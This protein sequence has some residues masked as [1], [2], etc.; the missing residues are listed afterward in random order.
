[1]SGII[2]SE[3]SKSGII[4]RTDG[5]LVGISWFNGNGDGNTITLEAGK[6]YDAVAISVGSNGP[7]VLYSVMTVASDGTVTETTKVTAS[8]FEWDLTTNGC[9]LDEYIANQGPH[10][11]MVFERGS[12]FDNS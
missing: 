10:W 5:R 8:G 7:D 2:G 6:T 9:N 4:G 11:G 12:T 3:G 1:M